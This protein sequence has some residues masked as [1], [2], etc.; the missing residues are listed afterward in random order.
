MMAANQV[1]F[2]LPLQVHRVL[3]AA[4]DELQR[5]KGY[6]TV[7]L[8]ETVETGAKLILAQAGEREGEG[9]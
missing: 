4:R 6:G 8:A 7:T 3:I 1:H 5:Q 9:S 2:A